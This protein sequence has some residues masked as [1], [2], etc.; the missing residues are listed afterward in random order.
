MLNLGH[1][2]CSMLFDTVHP[3]NGFRNKAKAY[4]EES[5]QRLLLEGWEV[6]GTIILLEGSFLH[7]VPTL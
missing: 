3:L 2:F 7:T 1:T 6:E 4:I 5:Q